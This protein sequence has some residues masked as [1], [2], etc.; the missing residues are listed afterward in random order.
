MKQRLVMAAED[1]HPPFF[2]RQTSQFLST[3]KVMTL[4]SQQKDTRDKER[5]LCLSLRCVLR[6]TSYAAMVKSDIIESLET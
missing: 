1:D 2:G 5:G 6:K 3:F 4:I